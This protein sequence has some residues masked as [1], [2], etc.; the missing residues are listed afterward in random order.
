MSVASRLFIGLKDLFC[1]NNCILSLASAVLLADLLLFLDV[2]AT[3]VVSLG[4]F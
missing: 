4:V 2:I 1:K 3:G